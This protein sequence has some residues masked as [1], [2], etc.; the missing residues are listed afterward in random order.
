MSRDLI[1]KSTEPKIETK[2]INDV[3]VVV[4][5]IAKDKRPVKFGEVFSVPYPNIFLCAMKQSGKTTCLTNIILNSVGKNTIVI[6]ISG[7]V[8]NDDVIKDCI[9]KL[10]KRG[11][12]VITMTDIVE[13]GVNAVEDF[14]NEHKRPANEEDQAN[15]SG[16]EATTAPQAIPIKPTRR[17]IADVLGKGVAVNV[18]KK[19]LREDVK[20]VKQDAKQEVKEETPNKKKKLSKIIPEY[21]IVLDDCGKSLRD[22]WVDRLSKA[23]RH[24]K[25]MLLMSSQDLNDLLPSTLKQMG[26]VILFRKFSDDKLVE[27][28][29]KLDLGIQFETFYK[30][31]K[32]AT[33]DKFNFLFID[34]NKNEFRKNFSELYKI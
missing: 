30:L 1:S 19:A 5:R 33:K 26:Y 32:D 29:K 10:E 3:K 21:I 15:V 31:Y 14:M 27:L 25:T 13:D 20:Q 4:P 23:N 34:R 18:E 17:S 12:E 9:R 28:F 11:N 16:H 24:N 22:V 7:S 8:H 6:I 2:T